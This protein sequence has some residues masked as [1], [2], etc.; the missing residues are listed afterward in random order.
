[1]NTVVGSNVL[2]TRFAGTQPLYYINTNKIVYNI[3]NARGNQ[4]S[5]YTGKQGLAVYQYPDTTEKDKP[6]FDLVLDLPV[7]SIHTLFLTGTVNAP[8]T[9]FATDALP[10]YAPADSAMGFRFI[11]LSPGSAAI[12]VN[13]ASNANGTETGGLGFKQYTGFQRYP[14]TLTTADYT[15]EFR[16]A[17]S[18]ALIA[19]Y[20]ASGINNPGSAF[21]NPWLYRN[22]TLALTGKPG[23]TGSEAQTAFLITH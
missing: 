20:T 14:V 1:V 19:T 22:Y 6:L 9:V 21:P 13:I 8:D 15:F 3:Y 23:G 5:Y 16:D 7:S 10:Y 12:T 2:C 11:N 18:Q 4:F 17:A